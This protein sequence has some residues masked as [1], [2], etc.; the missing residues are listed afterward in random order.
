[1]LDHAPPVGVGEPPHLHREVAV[2]DPVGRPPLSEL[3]TGAIADHPMDECWRCPKEIV[4][5]ANAVIALEDGPRL[6]GPD[7]VD[8]GRYP[9]NMIRR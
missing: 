3:V 5:L 1:M 4:N 9:P 7:P 2:P 6:V 8:P